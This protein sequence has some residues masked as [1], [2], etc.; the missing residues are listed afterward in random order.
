[1]KFTWEMN[2]ASIGD[3]G[4][5]VEPFARPNERDE[6]F[7]GAEACRIMTAGQHATYR[8]F[9]KI[10]DLPVRRSG[11]PASPTPK[12]PC[13]AA[14]RPVSCPRAWG[15][16][17]AW[18]ETRV[19]YAETRIAW[20]DEA[21]HRPVPYVRAGNTSNQVIAPHLKVGVGWI[22]WF[23]NADGGGRGGASILCG[24]VLREVLR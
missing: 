9:L 17:W 3:A 8:F 13:T 16:P 7:P 12:T 2:S 21:L 22:G 15:W 10:G 19:A 23:R 5:Y 11:G 1:M 24:W 4:P 6:P 14:I 20:T 18:A